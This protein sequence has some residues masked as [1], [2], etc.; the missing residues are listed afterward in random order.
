MSSGRTLGR[1][2]F[3][4]SAGVALIGA[5]A[6]L[7]QEQPR[8]TALAILQPGLWQVRAEGEPQRNVCVGD[9]NALIQLRHKASACTRLVIANEKMSATIHYS[10][11]GSGWGRTTLRVETPR[12][13]RID[14]QGI[15]GNAPFAFVAEARRIGSCSERFSADR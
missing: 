7:S 4:L 1:A 5:T 12:L 8:L 14:T 13:A 11:P 15:M 6:A 10:C 9:T 3:M 2:F